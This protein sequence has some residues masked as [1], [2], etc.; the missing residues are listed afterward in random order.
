MLLNQRFVVSHPRAIV[1]DFFGKMEEVVPCMPGASLTEPPAGELAKFQFNVKLG[2]ISVSFVGDARL[3]RDAANFRGVIRGNARDNRG[4]SRVKSVV[5]YALTEE[6]GGARTAVD[7]GVDFTLTGR[8][9]QFSRA[10]IV[11]DLAARLTN[12]FAQNLE[13]ALAAQ[14]SVSCSP[15]SAAETVRV[16]APKASSAEIHA[17]RLLVSVIWD[18]MVALFRSMF[19]R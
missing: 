4:D 2:P 5:E 6:A 7:I 10:G 12:D 14:T 8:L 3:E 13:V 17:G 15:P 18:R 9:A 1:W 11:N 19:R 16:P